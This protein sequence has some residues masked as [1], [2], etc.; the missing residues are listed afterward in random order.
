[1][2]S[3]VVA[4]LLIAGLVAGCGQMVTTTGQ[5]GTARITGV[6]R[7]HGTT[8]QNASAGLRPGLQA[9][10]ACRDNRRQLETYVVNTL[11]QVANA[12]IYVRRG[13]E[14]AR[15]Q[16]P[17]EPVVM[18]R[19]NCRFEPHVVGVMTKQALA[20]SNHDDTY[21]Y[22]VAQ[23][24]SN[25][26]FSLT[27]FPTI[28]PHHHAFAFPEVVIKVRCPTHRWM[29][30]YVAVVDHPFFSVSAAD[31]R[32]ALERLPAGTYTIE[33]WHEGLGTLQQSISVSQGETREI[34]FRFE[35]D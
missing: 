8:P 5:Y 3:H 26:E 28:A 6:V 25:G 17:A 35:S 18:I 13:L 23:S 24:E 1:M 15:Y 32:F 30:A 12:F 31:G 16:P 2:I 7:L 20:I 11:G 34:D 4:T 33:A 21:H 19:R 29:T 10:P 9:D 14:R 27:Q 22:F